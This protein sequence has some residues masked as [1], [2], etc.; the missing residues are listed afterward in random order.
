M[1]VPQTSETQMTV[2]N[3]LKGWVQQPQNGLGKGRRSAQGKAPR[4]LMEQ[5]AEARRGP[6]GWAGGGGLMKPGRGKYRENP[7][8]PHRAGQQQGHASDCNAVGALERDVEPK[9]QLGFMGTLRNADRKPSSHK[10]NGLSEAQPARHV[11]RMKGDAGRR[12]GRRRHSAWPAGRF[13][14]EAGD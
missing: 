5:Q 14:A 3:H 9:W 8:S 12:R 11:A 1:E 7:G 13:S 10:T 6:R 2:H 4:W